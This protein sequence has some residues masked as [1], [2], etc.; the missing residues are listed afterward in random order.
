MNHQIR[1]FHTSD[2]HLG[3][4]LHERQR[5]D[6][7]RMFLD[8][9]VQKIE[10][11]KIDVLLISGDI[12]DTSNASHIAQ[13]Q[14]Y[15]FCRRLSGTCCRHAVITSG[16]H[17]STSFIDVPSRVLECLNV[18]V[19]GQARFNTRS[20]DP[21]D[22]VIVL[23]DASGADELIV[24]AVP[25]LAEGDVRLSEGGE[26]IGAREKNVTDGIARHYE[27]VAQAAEEI[28]AG[29]DIPVVAMGHLF[30]Q[31]GKIVEDDGVRVTYV[32]SLG[33]VNA[34]IFSSTYDYV[35][36]GHLHVPQAVGDCEYIRYSGSPIA[37]GF[38][39]AGQQ[40][41]ICRVVFNGRSQREISM[42][43]IPVFHK[44]ENVCGDQKEIRSRL[45]ELA[46]LGEEIYISVI[47][48]GDD[49]LDSVTGIIEDIL[50]AQKNIICLCTK[51]LS[52]RS[53][54]AGGIAYIRDEVISEINEQDMFIKLLDTNDVSEA[55]RP[56]LISTFNELLDIVQRE[57]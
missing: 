37:M 19:I 15:N 51:N 13:R 22:E 45:M 44:I 56:E 33:G 47:Y 29:R 25:F 34:N 30:V 32:G 8:W 55:E 49:P 40:K 27:L 2:W 39:E 28:R 57:G 1:I 50:E 26:D 4:A 35:A 53:V 20:G 41:S 14:Y 12:F 16:N 43:E 46:A 38:G 18:H 10:D 48:H 24:A 36:L 42:C 23:K 17:D 5:D 6:E 7:Y 9:L 3:R 11:E 52:K 21:K 54:D 31:G